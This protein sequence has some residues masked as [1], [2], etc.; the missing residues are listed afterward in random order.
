PIRVL[1]VEWQGLFLKRRREVAADYGALIADEIITPRKVLE[2][3]LRGP[4]SD[5]VFAMARKQLQVSLDRNAGLAK[6]LVV[7]TLGSTRYQDM[8]RSITTKVMDR[9]PETMSYIEDYARDSMD[10]R[11]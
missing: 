2:A 4:L 10:V 8:K 11:N 6:P 3:V 1:G 9:L 7:M 5:R